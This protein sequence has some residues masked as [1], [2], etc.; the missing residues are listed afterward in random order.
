MVQCGTNLSF[1]NL[2]DRL[3]REVGIPIVA[4]NATWQSLAR[5]VLSP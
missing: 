4:I 2:A 5:C 3:E 1:V